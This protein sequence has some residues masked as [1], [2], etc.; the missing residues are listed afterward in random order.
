MA[1]IT[2]AERDDL[3]RVARLREKVAKT[4]A[5]RRSAE[6]LADFEKQLAS[7][8]SFDQSEV[9][10]TAHAAADK[11]LAE[12]NAAIAENCRKLGI[13]DRFAP[14]LVMGWYGRRENASRER[15]V[16]L[17]RVAVTRIA[18]IEK[19]ARAA[20]EEMSAEVQTELITNGMSEVP[21][22]L[23][24]Q[25]PTAERLMPSLTVS[26]VEALLEANA[27]ERSLR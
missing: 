10:A 13:P 3:L 8:Y 24:A 18:A 7:I 16:E 19:E 17:R 23:L 14:G 1:A 26:E 27:G 15:R 4:A 6:L 20:I 25:M 5:A 11:A 22:A 9:W 12:A 21:R 2:K